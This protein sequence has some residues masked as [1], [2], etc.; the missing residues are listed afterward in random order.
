MLRTH[1]D[2]VS[3]RV[4][5]GELYCRARHVGTML[6]EFHHFRDKPVRRQYLRSTLQLLNTIL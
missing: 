2:E 1:C 3:P 5:T 6:S 4:C